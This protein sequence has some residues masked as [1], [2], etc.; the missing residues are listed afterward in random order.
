MITKC[1]VKKQYIAKRSYKFRLLS[2][3]TKFEDMNK[4]LL[5]T[6]VTDD[7]ILIMNNWKVINTLFHI[8]LGFSKREISHGIYIFPCTFAILLHNHA[9][10]SASQTPTCIQL[11]YWTDWVIVVIVTI[12]KSSYLPSHLFVQVHQTGRSEHLLDVVARRSF[13]SV[14]PVGLGTFPKEHVKVLT[15]LT[16]HVLG[17]H[18]VVETAHALPLV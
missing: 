10:W 9:I 14:L 13:T 8:N 3:S 4:K 12:S 18:E 2:T 15:Q 6:D 11:W 7:I 16:K 5:P 1:Y 17:H